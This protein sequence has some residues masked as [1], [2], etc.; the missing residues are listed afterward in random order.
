MSK[1]DEKWTAWV[2]RAYIIKKTPHSMTTRKRF[3]VAFCAHCGLMALKNDATKRALK[4]GC[5]EYVYV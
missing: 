2:D 5:I 1:T 4:Q 3:P